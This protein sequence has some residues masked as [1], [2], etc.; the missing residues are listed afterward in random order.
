M[1]V[2]ARGEKGVEQRET[3]LPSSPERLV[4]PN[5][6]AHSSVSSIC[7]GGLNTQL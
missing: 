1:R 5:Q 4:E 7:F 2:G 6:P 3:K